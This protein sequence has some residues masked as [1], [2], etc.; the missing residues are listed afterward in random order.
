MTNPNG[1]RTPNPASA[2]LNF[3]R[4]FRRAEK[5]DPALT[6]ASLG[7]ACGVSR[8]AASLWARTGVPARQVHKVAAILKCSVRDLRPDIFRDIDTRR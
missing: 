7:D 4:A 2:K 3:H 8:Q 1:G 5:R 6:Y